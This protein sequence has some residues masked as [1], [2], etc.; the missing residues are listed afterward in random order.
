[1][2]GP[3]LNSNSVHRT[4][5]I[6]WQ[7]LVQ[8]VTLVGQYVL[9]CHKRLPRA[10]M[11]SGL[12]PNMPT[13]RRL[14]TGAAGA[15]LALIAAPSMLRHAAAQ[16]WRA[17]DP[18]SLGV[19]SGAPRPDGFVL[20]TR[21]APEPLSSNPETPG[22]MCGGNV[23]VGYE[24]A[25]DPAM[26]EVVRR[27]AASAEQ[28]FAY[29]VHLDVAGLA[30]WT[31]VLVSL[32]ERRRR[33]AASA[34]PSRCR[35]PAH[36]SISCASASCPARTTSTAIFPAIAISPTRTR[37]SCC[38][39]ATT[40]TNTSRRGGRPCAATPTA[41]KRR[42]SPTYRNRY[43]QY[44]LD[45]DLQRL[46]AEV[47]ALVTWDDH[48]VQDDYAD[49]WSKIFRRPGAVPHSPRGGVPGVLRA[50]AGAADP[51]A[52][53]KDRSCGSMIAS[54]SATSSRSR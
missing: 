27:G 33:R 53:A 22:G 41:S 15:S 18:F 8:N 13:R 42:R 28:A 52:A 3:T 1:M 20:W 4:M 32:H 24:I 51:V 54:A 31:V 7:N 6:A 26:R 2:I 49:K 19:A 23:P 16:S 36:R 17:G 25:T 5:I 47:P 12:P 45:P 44:R 10:T 9:I 30:A 48:E 40:S 37:N 43:A 34:A 21:L 11:S 14:L 35:R 46:H 38:S 29:S 39:S 50:H